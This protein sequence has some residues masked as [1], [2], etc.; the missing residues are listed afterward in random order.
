MKS[1][2]VRLALSTSAFTLAAALAAPLAAQAPDGADQAEAP[3]ATD[4]VEPDII[5]TG[6]L[7]QRPNNTSVSP[8]ISVG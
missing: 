4:R 2:G 5:V 3:E 7:I 1:K 6:S 8:I